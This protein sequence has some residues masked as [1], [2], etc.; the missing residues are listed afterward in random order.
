MANRRKDS[1]AQTDAG[2]R[3]AELTPSQSGSAGGMTARDVGSRDEERTAKGADA[4]I[5]LVQ[6]KD[7]LQ[8]PTA[9]R[10]D[11]RGAAR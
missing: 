10:S 4:E 7:K 9:T 1:H 3:D 6:K 11:H 2:L 8:P 5:K